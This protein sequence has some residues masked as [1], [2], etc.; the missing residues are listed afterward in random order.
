[1]ARARIYGSE[2]D[3]AARAGEWWP[4]LQGWSAH[5]SGAWTRGSDVARHQ[6]L[7]SVGPASAVLGLRYD[8]ASGRWGSELLTTLVAAKGAV[9]RS[10]ADL[11]AS[12]GYASFDWRANVALG[13][14][15]RLEAAVF[16]LTDRAY[17]EWEDVRGRAR[18]DPLLP[19]YTRPGRNAAL[20]LRWSY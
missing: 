11:Y 15:L 19:Y 17:V 8:A 10:R 12:P 16:N 2:L 14:G 7:N 5:V 1:V 3:L 4:R 20:S 6:P 13:G 18:A 9:D